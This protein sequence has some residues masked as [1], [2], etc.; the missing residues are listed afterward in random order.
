MFDFIERG[1]VGRV[2]EVVEADPTVLALRGGKDT[3]PPLVWAARHG[4]VEVMEVL[5]ELG[6][7]LEE[8]DRNGNTA[9]LAAAVCSQPG[10]VVHLL[11]AGADPR[12]RGGSNLTALHGAAYYGLAECVGPLV[13]AGGELDAQ[14]TGGRTPLHWASMWGR[15][16]VVRELLAHGADPSL[17][18]SSSMV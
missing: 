11:R 5:L 3:S 4:R 8:R 15:V 1:E 18:S 9:L 17:V 12:A 7:G 2:R 16:E 13:E 6:A 10:A 14:D